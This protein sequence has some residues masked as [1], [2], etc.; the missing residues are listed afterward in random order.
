MPYAFASHFAPEQLLE[1]MKIY[2]E[3]LGHQTNKVNLIAPL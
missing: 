2:R 1:V 3:L